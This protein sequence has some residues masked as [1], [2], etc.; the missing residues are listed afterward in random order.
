MAHRHESIVAIG[1][2]GQNVLVAI[3]AQI[4]IFATEMERHL[5]TRRGS[6]GCQ[7]LY[8]VEHNEIL[9]D[10]GGG[11]GM[12]TVAISRSLFISRMLW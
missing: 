2:I 4:H 12:A 10:P 7:Y 11:H 6:R 3:A 1:G 5:D 8:R 9:T